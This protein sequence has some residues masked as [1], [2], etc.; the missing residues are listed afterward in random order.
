M[1]LGANRYQ[2]FPE[3]APRASGMLEAD[4]RHSLYWEECGNSDGVP[5]LFIHGGPGAGSFPVHRRFFDPD[6]Y[7]I[8]LFDQRGAGRSTPLAE[9]ADNTTRHLVDDMERLRRH[10][11]IERWLLFGGSWGSALALVYGIQHPGR[12]L[13]FVL[14][15]VFL[16]RS[17][18]TDWF[19]YGLRVVFPEAWRAF[20]GHLPAAE[21]ADLLGGYLRRLNDPDPAVHLPA[22]RA[23]RRY[24]GVCST[25]LPGADNAPG[26]RGALALARLEAH[27]FANAMFLP[28]GWI[29]DN[30]SRVA[31]LPAI[32]VQGRYDMV[33]PIATADELAQAWPSADYTVVPDAGHSALEPGIRAALVA[34]TEKMKDLRL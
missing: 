3:I 7:R 24:E 8:V 17:F 12:C 30:L 11:G 1:D 5:A 33:C 18:E 20:A 13:G 15:G 29:L 9:T 23:W 2:L 34:A 16:C 28:E 6:H 27:Y 4:S 10:L 22:A 21:Q 14:R 32:I 25:L 19:L 26:D 31:H